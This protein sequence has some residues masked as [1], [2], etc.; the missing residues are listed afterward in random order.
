MRSRKERVEQVSRGHRGWGDAGGARLGPA[1]DW[2]SQRVAVAAILYLPHLWLL[3]DWC[4]PRFSL[5]LPS[6]LRLQTN[7]A[8][9]GYASTK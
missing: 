2:P 8:S 4:G 9:T 5:G 6:Y 3:K 1:P 7:H